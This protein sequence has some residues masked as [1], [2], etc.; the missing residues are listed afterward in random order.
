MATNIKKTGIIWLILFFFVS[1][2]VIADHNATVGLFGYATTY[3]TLNSNLILN[4]YNDILSTDSINNVLLL[5]PGF[6]FITITDPTGWTHT[7]NPLNYITNS[8]GISNDFSGNFRFVAKAD[9]LT[10]DTTYVWDVNTTSTNTQT[11]QFTLIVLNDPTAPI[12]YE[13]YP[14]QTYIQ[15]FN[16]SFWI[17]A[18]DDETGIANASLWYG[19]C[20]NYTEY[21][22]NCTGNICE[23]TI[24]LSS[25]PD[26]SA[27]CYYFTVYNNADDLSQSENLTTIIDRTAPTVTATS[28]ADNIFI[29]D[30]PVVFVFMATDNVAPTLEC[31]L[32]FNGATEETKTVLNGIEDN[33]TL[34]SLAD[35]AYNWSVSCRDI[36]GWVNESES[37]IFTIDTMPPVTDIQIESRYYRGTDIAISA[38]ITDLGSG[39]NESTVYAVITTPSGATENLTLTQ[40][41]SVYSSVYS[42]T[43]DS[44]LG[45]YTIIYYSADNLGNAGNS[46]AVF[47]LMYS[48]IVTLN[49]NPSTIN[50]SNRKHNK[51]C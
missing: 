5:T 11:Q 15:G 23:S 6:S 44:E 30:L 34:D 29:R 20:I 8:S 51:L 41:G 12:I 3:E 19:D 17:N 28:P 21:I 16:Q 42:T 50:V 1:S 40:S 7:E 9:K 37:R 32:I 39:V 24:D 25:L 10:A 48:Y 46:S 45:D 38:N 36:A 33:F 35:G 31:S 49:L 26:S 18:T 27:L 13:V 14:N 43:Y 4:I 47:S 22:L 2:A